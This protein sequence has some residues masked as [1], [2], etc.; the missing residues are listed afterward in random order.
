MTKFGPSGNEE[1]FYAAGYKSSV[2]MPEYA[3]AMGLDLYEYQCSKG[4]KITQPTA[5][6]LGAAAKEHGIGLSIHAPY[7]INLAT[8]DEEKRQKSVK[9]I[10]DTMQAAEWMGAVKI[11]VHSGACAKMPRDM[12]M[13]YAKKTLAMALDKADE[14]GLGHIHICPETMGKINQLG[15]LDEV[16]ELCK[17]DERLLPTIDFG[18]LNARTFGGIKTIDDYAAI[19][20]TIE[21]ALGRERLNQFHAHFSRIEFTTPGG[22]KKHHTFDEVEFGPEYLPLME[23]LAKK[24]ISPTIVCES[25]GTMARD[26]LRMKTAYLQAREARAE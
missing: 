21:N 26:A 14:L 2:Q 5:E 20:D 22:E 19:L 23:L 25:A 4:V 18:H 10:T 3:H 7:Y 8:D 9:Y 11:V 24:D 1:A 13:E 17:L 6:K 15:D 12:A 16:M